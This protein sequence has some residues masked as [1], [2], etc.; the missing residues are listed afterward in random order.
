[1]TPDF[2]A[3]IARLT[4]AGF[5]FVIVGG[6][7]AVTHGSAQV[8][9]DLDL[10]AVLT[11]ET[12]AVLREALRDWNPRHR[13]TPQRFSFLDVPPPGVPVNNLYL[14]T[15]AGVIDVLTSVLG[16]GDF[17]RVKAKA[18]K[19]EIDGRVCHVMSL[20]D[21][22]MAKDAMDRDKDAITATELRVIAAKRRQQAGG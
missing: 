6:Y 19:L 2:S 22:I 3:L 16:V 4:D 11:D 7:A 17:A 15:D 1:M 18:E 12:M 20:E 21:L 13:M 14:Q 5:D 10:C 8:T 9:R